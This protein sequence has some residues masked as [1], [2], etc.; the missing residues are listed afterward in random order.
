L[1]QQGAD[2]QGSGNPDGERSEL[3]EAPAED[4]RALAKVQR[5]NNV[6]ALPVREPASMAPGAKS[7]ARRPAP[8]KASKEPGAPRRARVEVSFEGSLEE[9]ARILRII[10]AFHVTGAAAVEHLTE[11]LKRGERVE[12]YEYERLDDWLRTG[13]EKLHQHINAYR[14]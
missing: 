9:K 11:K 13:W 12:P 7:L 14:K 3:V 8:K 4:V 10:G 5:D 1:T 6:V 2:D